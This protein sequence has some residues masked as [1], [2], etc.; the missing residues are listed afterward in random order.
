MLPGIRNVLV[1]SLQKGEAGPRASTPAS[2][3]QAGQLSE[4]LLTPALNRGK[5]QAWEREKFGMGQSRG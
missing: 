4:R 5:R 2:Q 1:G 3:D